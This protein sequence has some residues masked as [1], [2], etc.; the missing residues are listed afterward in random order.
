M[1]FLPADDLQNDGIPE[2]K[3]AKLFSAG[4][5]GEVEPPVERVSGGLMHRMFRVRAAGQDYAVKLLNPE[6]MKRPEAMRNYRRAESLERILEEAG[7]PI[8]PALTV[9]GRPKGIIYRR[10]S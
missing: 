7:L 2:E 3:I 8:V 9:N 10:L 4:G 6:I 5:F 1:G